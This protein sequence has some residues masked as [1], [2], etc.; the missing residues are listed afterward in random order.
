MVNSNSLQRLL[1][2]ISD[3]TYLHLL[4]GL[5]IHH[6][7]VITIAVHFNFHLL[8]CHF[9]SW[10]TWFKMLSGPWHSCTVLWTG[11]FFQKDFLFSHSFFIGAHWQR[12]IVGLILMFP[13]N[14]F[15]CSFT[16]VWKQELHCSCLLISI[17]T[18]VRQCLSSLCH[19]RKFCPWLG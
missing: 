14:F 16:L 10:G 4:G 6:K 17:L 13:G 1:N 2:H 3:I 5:L 8:V 15:A 7:D 18:L 19:F 12:Q 11:E 9:L